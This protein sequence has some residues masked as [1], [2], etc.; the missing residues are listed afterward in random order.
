MEAHFASVENHILS[1]I[2][3]YHMVGQTSV[4]ENDNDEKADDD[5]TDNEYM[6]SRFSPDRSSWRL[7]ED[8]Y[9]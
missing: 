1:D 9:W 5:N 6:I 7:G 3:N 4:T 8:D 2:H